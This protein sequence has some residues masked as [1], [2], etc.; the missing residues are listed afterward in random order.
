MSQD[1]IGQI[2]AAEEQAA[3]LF[4][5]ATERAAEMR[6]EMQRQA[7]AHLSEVERATVKECEQKNAECRAQIT[8]L[9]K[10]RLAAAEAEVEALE[11][12]ARENMKQAVQMIVW[13]L[14]EK[15]Q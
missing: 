13:G 2:T 11:E 1:A 6:A 12:K 10:R 14:V 4:R 15:C 5:V 3:V 7:E 8:A 9:A